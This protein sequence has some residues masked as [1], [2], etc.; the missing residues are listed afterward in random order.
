MKCPYSGYWN[1]IEVDKIFVKQPSSERKVRVMIPFYKPMKVGTCKK[2][3]Q[4]IAE[5][6]EL[7]KIVKKAES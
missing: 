1:R 6:K 5:P 7:I 4:I 2:C 3:G